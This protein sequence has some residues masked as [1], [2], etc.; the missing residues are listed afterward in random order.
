M[1]LSRP[2]TVGHT[3]MPHTTNMARIIFIVKHGSNLV[4][5]KYEG[6]RVHLNPYSRL[7]IVVPVAKYK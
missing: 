2:Y 4:P 3:E 1:H 6:A 5:R 7:L